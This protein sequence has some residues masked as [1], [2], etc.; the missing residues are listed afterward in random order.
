MNE[1]L[2]PLYFDQHIL[3]QVSSVYGMTQRKMF[4]FLVFFPPTAH[5]FCT[6]IF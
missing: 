4:W 2:S 5:V 3:V 1:A 6:M